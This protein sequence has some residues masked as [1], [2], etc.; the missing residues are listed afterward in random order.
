MSEVGIELVAIAADERVP[1]GGPQLLYDRHHL[2]HPSPFPL[3]LPLGL[4]LYPTTSESPIP[5]Q[6]QRQSLASET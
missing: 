6:V 1:P 3:L 4:Q 2:S 5:R